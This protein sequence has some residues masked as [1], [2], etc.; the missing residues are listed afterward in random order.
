V[1]VRAVNVALQDMPDVSLI[2]HEWAAHGTCTGLSAFDY[3]STIVQ[4]RAAVR[5]PPRLTAIR[6]RTRE[7]QISESPRQIERQFAEAN[8]SFP[9]SAF[10]T[11]CP[12]GLFQEER[13]CFDKSL[14]PR[15]CA[16]NAGGC[17]NPAVI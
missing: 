7:D 16:G 15:A 4:A 12:R 8:P 17:S 11:S 13:I 10:R 6:D 5:I 9:G 14:R 3:F 1:P 2:H